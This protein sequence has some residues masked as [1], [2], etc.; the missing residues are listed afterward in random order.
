[1]GRGIEEGRAERQKQGDRLREGGR[2]MR[3]DKRKGGR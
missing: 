3:K 2:G 1:M